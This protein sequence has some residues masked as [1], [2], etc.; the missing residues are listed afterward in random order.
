MR[1][2][3]RRLALIHAAKRDVGLDDLAYRSLLA[4]AAG[5]E[6]AAD[7]ADDRQ[8]F[9]VM[10]AFRRAGWRGTGRLQGQMKAAYAWWCR[11]GEAGAVDRANYH[12]L[13]AYIE[14]RC[15]K[16]D[17]YRTD[18]AALRGRVSEAMAQA[19]Y[20]IADE[21]R[22][23]VRVALPDKAA[24]ERVVD[25]ILDHFGGNQ[26]WVPN[27]SNYRRSQRDAAI[28]ADH[29][30]GMAKREIV[31]KYALSVPTVRRILASS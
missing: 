31:R 6:S 22:S 1:D 18:P 9:A 28:R 15:G 7:L 2:R 25:A 29:Q 16:Q 23:I 27:R 17:I 12:T 30:A 4:G 21:L 10:S 20:P 11:L 24:A 3:R 5:V 26:I 8:Y 13:M 19:R 14:R